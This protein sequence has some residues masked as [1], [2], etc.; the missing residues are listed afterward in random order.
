MK[1]SVITINFNNSDGSKSVL[2]EYNAQ[3]NHWIS[4]EDGGIYNAMNKGVKLSHGE[5]CI[6]VNSG[7]ILY[8]RTSIDCAMKLCPNT[9]IFVGTVLSMD[10]NKQISPPPSREI[11][12]YHL[13]S[14]A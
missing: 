11:S 5:Y 1:L 6:F 4:E 9:D 7:D 10:G 3:I 13:F 14:C 8:D 2:L 12:L